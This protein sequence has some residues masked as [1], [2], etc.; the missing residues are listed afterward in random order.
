[1]P[2]KFIVFVVRFPF[3]GLS[4]ISLSMPFPNCVWFVIQIVLAYVRFMY[5]SLNIGTFHLT[6][7]T[8]DT[9][10]FIIIIIIIFKIVFG[11]KGREMNEN[12]NHLMRLKHSFVIKSFFVMCVC[13]VDVQ[14]EEVKNN[15][16]DFVF[17]QQTTFAFI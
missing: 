7:E 9:F 13:G 16:S 1:M 2:T 12:H 8:L 5:I 10:F 6:A 14:W 11:K 17:Q 3:F 4:F 15:L